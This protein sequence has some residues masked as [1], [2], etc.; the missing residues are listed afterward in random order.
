M[1]CSGRLLH[2]HVRLDKQETCQ[3]VF[4]KLVNQLQVKHFL[5]LLGDS[6]HSHLLH[7]VVFLSFSVFMLLAGRDKGAPGL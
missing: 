6:R 4:S 1:M 3:N 7:S 5:E 2:V